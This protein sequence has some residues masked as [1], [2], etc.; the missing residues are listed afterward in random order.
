[1]IISFNAWLA[2]ATPDIA[3]QPS[4]LTAD[5]AVLSGRRHFQGYPSGSL[6]Y[7]KYRVHSEG[8]LLHDR[9]SWPVGS[10]HSGHARMKA[11]RVRAQGSRLP[12]KT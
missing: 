3:P 10:P 11:W 9:T 8:E 1:M 6:K 5:P 7:P 4:M 12:V 2:L